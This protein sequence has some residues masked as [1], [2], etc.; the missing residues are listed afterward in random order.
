[1]VI[2]GTNGNII[3]LDHHRT[4]ERHDGSWILNAN[5]AV[6]WKYPV[7]CVDDGAAA[8]FV[9]GRVLYEIRADGD[10]SPIKVWGA[11]SKDSSSPACLSKSAT[12]LGSH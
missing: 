6:T 1:V 2:L 3:R 5:S 4:I 12:N 8:Q 10:I 9:T 7:E 11:N